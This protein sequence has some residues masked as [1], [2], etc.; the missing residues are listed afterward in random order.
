LELTI[1]APERIGADGAVVDKLDADALRASLAQLR[2]KGGIDALTICFV[3]SYLNSAH[4]KQAQ[5]IAREIFTGVPVSISSDV[6]PEMQEYERAETT[7]VNAYVLPEVSLYVNNLQAAI[8][9]TLVNTTQLSILRS[10]GGLAWLRSEL[11]LNRRL[12]C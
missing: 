1:E 8:Q 12:I 3:N 10:D 9:E 4:E 7:V 2:A 11:Q 6:I 5:E